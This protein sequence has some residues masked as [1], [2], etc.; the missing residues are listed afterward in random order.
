[1]AVGDDEMVHRSFLPND[2]T[3]EG[4]L[5]STAFNDPYHCPSVDRAR[6]RPDPADTQR[7]PDCGVAQLLTQEIRAIDT[8]ERTDV[9]NGQQIAQFYRIDVIEK[10]VEP[11]NEQGIPPNPAHA[12]IE[13]DPELANQKRFRKMKEALSRLADRREWLIQP[14]R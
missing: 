7:G 11:G 12:Q 8:V 10:P 13:S 5:S 6:L 4:K 14:R 2:V 3:P 1:M 9:P